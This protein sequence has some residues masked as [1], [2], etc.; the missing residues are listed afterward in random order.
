MQS[1]H[2]TVWL[3]NNEVIRLKNYFLLSFKLYERIRAVAMAPNCT[4]RLQSALCVR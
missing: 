1:K 3:L 4:L 2:T